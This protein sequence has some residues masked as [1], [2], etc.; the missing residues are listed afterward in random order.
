MDFCISEL[1]RRFDEMGATRTEVEVKLF[2]GA[3]VLPGGS[4]KQPT[5][6]KLNCEAAMEVLRKEGVVVSGASLGDRFGRKIRF[7]TQ[8]GDVLM[9]R[10]T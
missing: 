1:A 8:T 3:D 5:V 7:N 10:L 6:G 2:G 9:M 4:A